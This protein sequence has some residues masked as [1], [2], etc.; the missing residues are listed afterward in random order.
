MLSYGHTHLNGMH[1]LPPCSLSILCPVCVCLTNSLLCLQDVDI[2][3][4]ALVNDTTGTQ[5]ALGIDDPE[6]YIGLILGWHGIVIILS[7]VALYIYICNF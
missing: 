1:H 2:D 3:V 6:C 5:M 7:S 4:V